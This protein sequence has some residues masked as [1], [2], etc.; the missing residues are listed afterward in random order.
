MPK[1]SLKTIA[2]FEFEE[3]KNGFQTAQEL[4]PQG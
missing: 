1:M 3:E 4:W 2:Q